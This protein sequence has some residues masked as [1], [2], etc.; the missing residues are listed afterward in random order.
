MEEPEFR[1]GL[2]LS[3]A[4]NY[5]R[6]FLRDFNFRGAMTGMG[7]IGN[8]GAAVLSRWASVRHTITVLCGVLYLA[9]RPGMW[10]RTVRDVLG[11]QVVFTGFD[12]LPLV[13]LVAVLAGVSIVSQAQLWLARIGQT[14]MLGSLL[15]SVLIREIAPLLVNFIVLGRSGTAV[16]TELANMRVHKEIE[17]LEGQGI[18][19]MQYL[20][21][22]RVLSFAACVFALAIFFSAI[23]F[24]SGFI[25]AGLTGSAPGDITGFA[26]NIM[27]A[28]GP[29]DIYGFLAK[30]LVSGAA[31]GTI[32]CIEGL[33]ACESIN[34]TPRAVTRTVV[35]SLATVLFISALVSLL[36]YV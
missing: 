19:T 17:V 1:F 34:E 31:A 3:N 15:V 21:M 30:T 22:P 12:A 32:S 18:D 28:V 11:R 27:G 23:A 10:P 33:G 2:L 6:E 14:A 9:V 36:T 20:V 25:F 13:A 8:T 5:E 29:A 26:E 35:K 24:L 7:I 16:A 4:Y